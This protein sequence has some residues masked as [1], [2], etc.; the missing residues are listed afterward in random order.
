M[1]NPY[2]APTADIDDIE[3]E[4]TYEPRIFA[5]S[6]RIGRLRYVGYSWLAYFLLYLV[7][8]IL[9]VIAAVTIPAMMRNGHGG[10]PALGFFAL[11]LIYTPILA[12]MFIYARRRLN[13]LDQSG[14]LSLLLIIPIIG[15][16]FWLYLVFA[17]GTDGANRFGPAPSKQSNGAVWIILIV[18][19]TIIVIGIL[20]AV[21]IP[22][23]QQYKAKAHAMQIEQQQQQQPQ[24]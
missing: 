19:V 14:W 22:A 5:V 2:T 15:F 23:Y 11:A 17:P 4:D 20:A 16:L 13:D 10:A 9:G 6:G 8:G 3:T 12:V 7:L 24:Q 21:A 18:V 1:N